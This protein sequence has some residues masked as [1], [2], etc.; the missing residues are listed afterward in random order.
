MDSSNF[1]K[2]EVVLTKPNAEGSEPT[3][4]TRLF[5]IVPSDETLNVSHGKLNIKASLDD[6]MLTLS[7][8]E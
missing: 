3:L 6:G 2:G 7:V 1:F 4:R 8:I 5:V